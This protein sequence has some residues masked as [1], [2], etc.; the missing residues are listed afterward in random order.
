M[1][2][3]SDLTFCSKELQETLSFMRE[4][5]GSDI[6]L[7]RETNESILAS[8]GKML[9]PLL[10]I[11]AAKASGTVSSSTIRYA[12][13]S[14][15]LHNATLLHDDVVDGA[16]CRRG[17]PTVASVL[18]G[19]ASV[20][21]GDF[22]LVRALRNILQAETGPVRVVGLFSETLG[23]LAEGEMLQLQKVIRCDTTEEEYL[24]I[25][26]CKTASLFRAAA[27]SGAISAGATPKEE[28]ALSSYAEALGMAFQIKD[29]IFDYSEGALIGKPV[30]QDL[31]EQKI[32][33]PLLGALREMS[34]EEATAL[35]GKVRDI[36]E[37]PQYQKEIQDLVTSRGGM[38]Y[39]EMRQAQFIGDA[40]AAAGLLRPGEARDA[41][42]ALAEYNLSRTK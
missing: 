16:A 42:V 9:R 5:L 7:L 10:T 25:I 11:L 28:D 32:T 21:I 3:A 23:D 15:L 31:L 19:T 30:G 40:I 20:L 38:E 4:S 13:A 1:R 34:P 12:A 6:A 37:H 27:L 14:E 39:A 41:L 18:G 29:D 35:R 17:K 26:R 36:Q 8:P 33:M 2:D 22:W 24:R